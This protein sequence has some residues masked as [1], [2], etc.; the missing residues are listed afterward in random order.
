MMFSALT[1]RIHSQSKTL[2]SHLDFMLQAN[3]SQSVLHRMLVLQAV[4]RVYEK[5]AFVV[6][7]IWK[8]LG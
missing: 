8:T 4:N 6:H 7:H 3:V 2:L 5:R 1:H